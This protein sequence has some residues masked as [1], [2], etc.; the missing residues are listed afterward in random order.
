[1]LPIEQ[2]SQLGWV[3]GSSGTPGI[4]R[5]RFDAHEFSNP[6]P[7]FVKRIKLAALERATTGSNYTIRWNSSKGGSVTLYR[8]TD[9]NPNNGGQTQI[10]T[11]SA[12]AGAGQFVW[13]ANAPG[14]H[15]IY[16]VMND[17]RETRT[18]RIHAGRLSSAPRARS[19]PRFQAASKS[20]INHSRP[21]HTRGVPA[22]QYP[23]VQRDANRI[24][25][26][27]PGI[28]GRRRAAVRG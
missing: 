21:L 6:T 8:D 16:V 27:K 3:P 9:R 5:F 24:R 2:G 18:A 23:C 14:Q 22:V 11:T 12:S 17:L 13:N 10:G 20:S 28:A 25:R 15:Y 7:F 1:M 4:D 19:L 26:Q